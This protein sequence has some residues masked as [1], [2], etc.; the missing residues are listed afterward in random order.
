MVNKKNVVRKTNKKGIVN[1]LGSVNDVMPCLVESMCLILPSY[2][3]GIPISILEAESV[4][5]PIITTNAPGCREVVIDKYNGFIVEIGNVD[6]LVEKIIYYIENFDKAKSDG[7]NSRKLVTEKY[8]VD[9]VNEQFAE[10]I[11]A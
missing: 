10:V 11:G 1:Y 6:E 8:S 5:R 4:G 7:E 9:K 3:E 2:R